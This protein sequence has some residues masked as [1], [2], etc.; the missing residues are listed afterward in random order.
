[1]RE[2]GAYIQREVKKLFSRYDILA[3]PRRFVQAAF[4]APLELLG[5]IKGSTHP[6]QKET[7]SKVRGKIAF[8]PIFR[9]IEQ[10]NR[11]ALEVLS[12]KDAW[13]PLYHAI[14]RP[15]VFLS[16]D[17]M[18]ALILHEQDLLDQWV[19]E[20]FRRLADELPRGKKWGIYSTSVLWG[21][22]ILSF[23]VIVGG[24]FTMLD[25][26]LDS[27]IAPFVTKGA[28]GLFASREIKQIARQLASR[29]EEGLLSVIV[30]Q[31]KRYEHCLA[32]LLPQEKSLEALRALVGS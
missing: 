8:T 26:V 1:M 13:A 5:I 23:E 10:M 6:G 25:A 21:I 4:R 27:V 16:E 31:K 11:E 14:R 30:H 12:P 9:T 17:E 2:S 32:P 18:T 24:G 19:E 28:V 20:R 15:D 3:K 7:L 29:Y 22:L